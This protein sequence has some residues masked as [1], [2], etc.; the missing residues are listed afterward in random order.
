[1]KKKHI[2]FLLI[3]LCID[4]FT[5]YIAV[6]TIAL[7]EEVVVLQDIFYFMN[8]QNY[9]TAFGIVEGHMFSVSI[10]TILSLVLLYSF[11]HHTTQEDYFSIA[12]ILLMMSGLMGNF[13]DRIFLGYVRDFIGVSLLGTDV[14]L[15]IADLLLWIGLFLIIY[16]EIKDIQVKRKTKKTC[17]DQK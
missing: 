16:S 1:M 11:Y 12:G 13:L 17:E 7:R 8:A 14:I 15:N 10:I 9:G 5:K 3:L 4:Q 6:H 2:E